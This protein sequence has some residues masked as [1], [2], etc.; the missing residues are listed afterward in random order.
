MTEI[1]YWMLKINEQMRDINTML[2]SVMTDLEQI[3]KEVDMIEVHLQDTLY[4]SEQ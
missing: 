3:N 2:D 4:S 1:E